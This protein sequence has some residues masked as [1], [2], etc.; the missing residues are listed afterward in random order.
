MKKKNKRQGFQPDPWNYGV[1]DNQINTENV[2]T[3]DLKEYY[4]PQLLCHKIDECAKLL[5]QGTVQVVVFIHGYGSHNTAALIHDRTRDYLKRKYGKF[6]IVAG[7]D[8]NIFNEDARMLHTQYPELDVLLQAC[9]HGVTV[10]GNR[11]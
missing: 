2:I 7:E 10:V 3:V 4:D 8:F 11:K 9:N 6:R 5:Q 1:F